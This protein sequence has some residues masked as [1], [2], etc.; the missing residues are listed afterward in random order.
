MFEAIHQFDVSVQ[1]SLSPLT[2]GGIFS[3]VFTWLQNPWAW[4]PFFCFLGL[5]VLQLQPGKQWFSVLFG[6]A[7]LVIAFQLSTWISNQLG[8]Q[9]PFAAMSGIEDMSIHLKRGEH[10]L[11]FPDW[12]VALTVACIAYTVI[13][14]RKQIS[15]P[16]KIALLVLPLFM[17]IA[18][19]AGGQCYLTDALAAYGVGAFSAFLLSRFPEHYEFLF[20]K[21]SS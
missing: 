18:R 6:V 9:A 8:R 19:I 17:V 5:L 20:E 4:A 2:H 11:S 3:N 13:L 10:P 14:L 12:A 15:K 16:W 21:E 7:S 1:Q